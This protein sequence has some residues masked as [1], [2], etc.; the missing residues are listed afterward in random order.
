[1]KDGADVGVDNKP[2]NGVDSNTRGSEASKVKEGR[3]KC[4]VKRAGTAVATGK[5]AEPSRPRLSLSLVQGTRTNKVT[6]ARGGQRK[7][8]KRQK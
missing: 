7:G 2:S 5:Q 3:R 4:K 6:R 1:L 8:K